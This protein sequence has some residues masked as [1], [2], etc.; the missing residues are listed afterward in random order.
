MIYEQIVPSL[1][2]GIISV[3]FLALQLIT[4]HFSMVTSMYVVHLFNVIF[5][6]VSLQPT[7]KSF[8]FY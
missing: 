8:A 2:K 4:P 7:H 1:I 3:S 6:L 5:T